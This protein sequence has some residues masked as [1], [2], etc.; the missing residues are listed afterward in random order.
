MESKTVQTEDRTDG[1]RTTS[2]Q[3]GGK[4]RRSGSSVK[5]IRFADEA[6]MQLGANE[7]AGRN[8]RVDGIRDRDAAAL[9]SHRVFPV[10]CKR[11]ARAREKV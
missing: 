1:W 11:R 5:Q 7:V 8:R 6:W 3:H 4:A 2:D 9:K 10:V